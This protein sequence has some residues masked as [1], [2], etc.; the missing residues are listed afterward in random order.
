MEGIPG[1]RQCIFAEDR[2]GERRRLRQ[3]RIVVGDARPISY[4]L[5][6]MVY[7]IAR[8]PRPDEAFSNHAHGRVD[9]AAHGRL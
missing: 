4:D 7:G 6:P 1:R 5:V 9:F 2:F 8:H 3:V